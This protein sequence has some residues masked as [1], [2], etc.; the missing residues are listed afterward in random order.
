MSDRIF[1]LLIIATWVSAAGAF[2]YSG[3]RRVSYLVALRICGMWAA[4]VVSLMLF[5]FWVADVFEMPSG[6]SGYVRG[7]NVLSP[8]GFLVQL[9]LVL[10]IGA[11]I[12]AKNYLR[13]RGGSKERTPSQGASLG[14]SKVLARDPTLPLISQ[15]PPQSP[16]SQPAYEVTHS[17]GVTGSA[18]FFLCCAIGN[19][20]LGVIA[21]ERSL[22]GL[23][24]VI[25][26]IC[27]LVAAFKASN[28]TRIRRK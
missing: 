16:E 9:L 2:F 10:E 4:I 3:G 5:N 17:F 11:L 6:S 25:V 24:Y 12:I 7:R 18:V 27:L 15:L 8:Y 19:F 14:Q 1:G 21:L 23:F 20:W 22:Y 13:S 28:K 26:G